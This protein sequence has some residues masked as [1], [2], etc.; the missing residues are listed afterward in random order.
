MLLR[1]V[2]YFVVTDI[3]SVNG[4]L[5]ESVGSIFVLK[6]PDSCITDK[7]SFMELN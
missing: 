7:V 4:V 5:F 6:S 3:L 1:A 2:H